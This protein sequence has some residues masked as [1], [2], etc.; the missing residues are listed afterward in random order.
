MMRLLSAPPALLSLVAALLLTSPL[1]TSATPYP[2]DYLDERDAASLQNSTELTKRCDNPCGW[3]G[4]LC[5]T[6][7]QTC[8]TDE[9]DQAQCSDGGSAATITAAA[10]TGDGGYWQYY[11]STWVETDL[12]TKTAVYST[13]VG[14]SVTAAAT[15]AAATP[16]CDYAS[17]ETPCGDICCASG[18]YC[19][20]SGQCKDAG[21]GGIT[22]TGVA[23]TYSPP[24][25]PTTGTYT[26]STATVSPTTTVPF[27]TPVATGSNVTVTGAQA[28]SHHGLSGGAIAGIVIGVL[29]ALALLAL[30]CF[31][32]I[33]RGLWG[34]IMGLFGG[35]KQKR[36]RVEETYVEEHHHH[37]S[38]AGGGRVWYG[39]RP[40]R[41]SRSRSPKRGWAPWAAGL[42]ALGLGLGAKKALDRRRRDEKSD[43]SSSYD[44]YSYYSSNSS[45]SSPGTL[46]QQ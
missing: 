40:S 1:R 32:C 3:Q 29:V 45:K 16:S 10:A 46:H 22:T 36:R 39:D 8:Y 4:Q 18:Q 33:V 42:G 14:A 30:L 13:F 34:L 5:C 28:S 27:G 12:V 25:R 43:I 44:Y 23:G 19:F 11:T 41:R 17:N 31:C 26:I 7:D 38:A 35:R 9:N 2:K 21:N 6:A 24:L 15:S 37:G 20:S